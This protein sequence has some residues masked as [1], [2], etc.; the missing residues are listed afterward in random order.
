MIAILDKE[1][2]WKLGSIKNI[3]NHFQDKLD[4]GIHFSVGASHKKQKHIVK[5]EIFI[6]SDMG[7]F[8]LNEVKMRAKA[9][10]TW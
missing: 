1:I 2:H 10:H 3:N 4:K 7:V 5:L 6:I 9:F 8:N